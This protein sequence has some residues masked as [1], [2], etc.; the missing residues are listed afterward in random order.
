MWNTCSRQPTGR[1]LLKTLA[2]NCTLANIT[3][4][5]WITLTW[6]EHVAN[7]WR[8]VKLTMTE[9]Y[10]TIN[11]ADFCQCLLYGTKT[12]KNIASIS[13]YSWSTPGLP[14]MD[15]DTGDPKTHNGGMTEWRKI[16]LNPKTRNSAKSP[17]ILRPPS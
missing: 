15:E 17:H 8:D 14:A 7:C 5:Q 1:P 9:T 16:T 10:S 12:F 6:A 11:D 4:E 2:L 13:L 3:S